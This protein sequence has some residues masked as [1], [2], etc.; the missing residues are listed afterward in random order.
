MAPANKAKEVLAGLGLSD[1]Q[2]D[3]IVAGIGQQKTAAEESGIRQK[4]FDLD[5][6]NAAIESLQTQLKTLTDQIAGIDLAKTAAKALDAVSEARQPV[7]E[8]YTLDDL[9]S[10]IA[11]AFK[12][13]ITPIIEKQ[14]KE[15]DALVTLVSQL[16]ELSTVAKTAQAKVDE[17]SG[18]LPRALK[19]PAVQRYAD[20]VGPQHDRPAISEKEENDSFGWVDQYLAG[21]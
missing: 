14:Q 20:A 11:T 5:Q 16:H 10:T 17:L 8:T 13:A 6:A 9:R 4:A 15:S 18:E 1:E 2:V 21:Q 3:A 7:Q 19:V 12:E